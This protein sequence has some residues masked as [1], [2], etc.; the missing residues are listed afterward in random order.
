[1]VCDVIKKLVTKVGRDTGTDIG[2]HGQ[3]RLYSEIPLAKN[4]LT[5]V[6]KAAYNEY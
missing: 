3:N 2:S 1:M 6:F 5:E 4:D